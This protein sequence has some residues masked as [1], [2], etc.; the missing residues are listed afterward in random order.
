MI[1][2]TPGECC[3]VFLL[4]VNDV[5]TGNR[6][7]GR[8]AGPRI[9]SKRPQPAGAMGTRA[10][11][12]ERRARASSGSKA[13]VTS[14][15]FGAGLWGDRSLGSRG[16]RARRAA[17]LGTKVR[18]STRVAGR[19]RGCRWVPART[20][21][22][23]G[24]ARRPDPLDV[25]RAYAAMKETS[26]ERER[27]LARRVAE[28]RARLRT[29]R[30]PLRDGRRLARAH[31]G[32]RA[33]PRDARAP[34]ETMVLTPTSTMLG[35]AVDASATVRIHG[36]T[37]A[38]P[39]D[40]TGR[41]RMAGRPRGAAILARRPRQTRRRRRRDA[42]REREEAKRREREELD[43][44]ADE[45]EACAAAVRTSRDGASTRPQLPSP[46]SPLPTIRRAPAKTSR[47]VLPAVSTPTASTTPARE[48]R[49]NPYPHA[50][51]PDSAYVFDAGVDDFDELPEWATPSK[52]RAEDRTRDLFADMDDYAGYVSRGP[53]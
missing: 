36:A 39:W 11:A 37:G 23:S 52:V 48:P 50:V 6:D 45:I 26:R 8:S 16:A 29:S 40:A 10:R 51:R 49:P 47:V 13:A 24:P 44:R 31:R 34:A 53:D 30:V 2:S 41:T 12:S 43:A 33:L 28:R 27:D 38:A 32:A 22:T 17:I 21:T 18:W 3:A 4:V 42:I 19:A 20:S 9:F 5:G 7:R 14:K 25:Q 46:P 15:R 35:S 1:F